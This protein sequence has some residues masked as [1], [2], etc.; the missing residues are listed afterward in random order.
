MMEYSDY[1]TWQTA[2]WDDKPYGG[3]A[4]EQV[5]FSVNVTYGTMFYYTEPET[6][7]IDYAPASVNTSVMYKATAGVNGTMRWRHCTLI[8]ALIKY[9]VEVTND[10]LRLKAMPLGTN[11]TT[12]RILRRLEYANLGHGMYGVSIF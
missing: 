3:L 8:E 11:R 9:P 4:V 1:D 2:G 10:T 5:A 7:E 12:Q 6:G